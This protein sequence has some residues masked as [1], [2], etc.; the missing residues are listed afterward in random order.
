VFLNVHINSTSIPKAVHKTNVTTH[1]SSP[2]NLTDC[3]LA[4]IQLKITTYSAS[5]MSLL[6]L[7]FAHILYSV[8]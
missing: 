7:S 4:F 5:T 6:L 3:K 1:T 8:K 2:Y